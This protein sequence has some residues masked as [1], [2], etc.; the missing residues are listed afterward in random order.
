MAV[1]ANKTPRRHFVVDVNECGTA[2]IYSGRNVYLRTVNMVEYTGHLLYFIRWLQY[3][4]TINVQQGVIS[5]I[6][7]KYFFPEI[8]LFRNDRAL[9]SV[10]ILFKNSW[11]CS[12]KNLQLF[13]YSCTLKYHSIPFVYY[14]LLI[15]KPPNIFINHFIVSSQ[16]L[17][18]VYYISGNK[19]HDNSVQLA[20][21]T[22]YVPLPN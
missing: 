13:L 17:S 6:W 20:L 9:N 2:V 8:F 15:V 12:L 1:A 22:L 11:D 14:C 10:I 19:Q 21:F 5:E 3:I 7:R 18:V 4:R 16:C